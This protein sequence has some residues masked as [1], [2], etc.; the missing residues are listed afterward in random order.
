MRVS[1]PLDLGSMRISS[2]IIRSATNEYA[3]DGEGLPDLALAGLYQALA[4]GE[5]PLIV[6]GYVYIHPGGRSSPVQSA[7]T[8][9]EHARRWAD[10]AEKTHAANGEVRIAMQIV[11]GGRQSLAD[12]PDGLLAPSPVALDDVTPREMT[13][14]DI[15]ETIDAFV[16]AAKRAVDAGIDAVQLHMAHG[17]LLSEFLSPHTNRRTDDFGGSPRRRRRVPLTVV[18]RVR[19]TIGDRV[20]ILVKMNCADFIPGGLEAGEAAEHAAALEDAGVD[21]IEISG[22]MMGG[23]PADAP[24]REGDPSSKDEAFFL[25]QARVMRDAVKRVPLGLCGGLRSA[26]RIEELLTDDGFDFVAMSRPFIAEPDL[27]VNLQAGAGRVKCISC[28]RCAGDHSEILYCPV[29]REGK[30]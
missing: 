20:P 22:W 25:S 10:I 12:L 21:G 9:D 15:E 19:E 14:R 11:H 30:L 3:G 16:Q 23:D 18:A 4:R 1:E 24:S 2:R 13:A 5:C 7:I 17:Y 28:N 27:V 8:T 6:T 29:V 26:R